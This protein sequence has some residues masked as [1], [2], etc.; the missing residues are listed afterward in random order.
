MELRI[1]RMCIVIDTNQ[2]RTYLGG[3]N[4]NY[5]PIEN[6]VENRKGKI[7]IAPLTQLKGKWS[8]TSKI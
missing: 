4:P 8:A 5:R 7:H 3:K 6:W 1:E 2:L